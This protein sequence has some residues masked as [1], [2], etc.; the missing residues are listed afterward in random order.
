MAR[1]RILKARAGSVSNTGR[2]RPLKGRAKRR[3]Q[4]IAQGFYVGETFHPIRASADYDPSRVGEGGKSKKA[5]AK[6]KGRAKTKPKKAAARRKPVARK[7][8]A[9]KKARR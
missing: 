2:F 9:K 5:K 7:K 4:N 3:A 6:K 8:A 1:V